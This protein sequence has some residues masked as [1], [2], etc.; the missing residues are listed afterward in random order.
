MTVKKPTAKNVSNV[1]ARTV[2]TDSLSRL[3][4]TIVEQQKKLAF[5]RK[6]KKAV[7]LQ[8]QYFDQ[9]E[10]DFESETEL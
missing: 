3:D 7:L 2:L 1:D 9:Y 6:T 5:L 8:I 10:L 4:K